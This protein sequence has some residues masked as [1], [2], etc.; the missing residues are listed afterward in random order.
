MTELLPSHLSGS[1]LHGTGIKRG[2]RGSQY[3]LNVRLG[4][5][6]S[7][8][9]TPVNHIF[10]FD[11]SGS[12]SGGNDP[13]GKRFEEVD[14]A[15]RYI[16]RYCTCQQ[17]YAT[18]IHFDTPTSGDIPPTLINKQGCNDLAQGLAVPADGGGGSNLSQSLAKAL[19]CARKNPGFATVLTVLSDFEL[20]DEP[21]VLGQ[22][23]S[24]PGSVHAIVFRSTP[25][26]I[27]TNSDQVAVTQIDHHSQPGSVA[28]AI[29]ASMSSVRDPRPTRRFAKQ[30]A[31]EPTW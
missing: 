11:N 28:K 9:H 23:V 12:M 24:F 17:E 4:H 1:S 8:P 6:G 19:Q 29:F 31:K 18:L 13:V 5:P 20:F 22:F 14:Y 3:Q 16:S 30:A 15:V 10:V 27:L 26:D 25:P 21:S 2:Q 7:C